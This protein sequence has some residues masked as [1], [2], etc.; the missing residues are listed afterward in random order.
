M[1]GSPR[2]TF[3]WLYYIMG[4]N[5]SWSEI[6]E[7][8]NDDTYFCLVNR[9][10]E[11]PIWRPQ[12]PKNWFFRGRIKKFFEIHKVIMQI[13]WS[14][15]K[16]GSQ[17]W[18]TGIVTGYDMLVHWLSNMGI[19]AAVGHGRLMVGIKFDGSM[20]LFERKGEHGN[21]YI[22]LSATGIM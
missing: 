12:P 14:M 1:G 20:D 3:K 5:T 22:Q 18:N 2:L 19:S 4:V 6:G 7:H 16:Y 21:S 9:F 13:M 10:W 17:S 8:A 11:T 15:V